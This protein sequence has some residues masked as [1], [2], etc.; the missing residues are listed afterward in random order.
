MKTW[1]VTI[2]SGLVRWLSRQ[3]HQLPTLTWFPSLGSTWWK[4]RIDSYKLFSVFHMCIVI[5]NAP[6]PAL[7]T[8]CNRNSLSG[9]MLGQ[10][11]SEAL[12]IFALPNH[13]KNHLE[14][15]GHIARTWTSLNS[16]WQLISQ[17]LVYSLC[18]ISYIS[19]IHRAHI[20]N[21]L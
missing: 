6:L 14:F 1:R 9:F 17:P 8:K 4:R 13:R 19:I 10:T 7:N 18:Q 11:V 21:W 20:L 2:C 12:C 5:C 15:Q 3:R 16:W